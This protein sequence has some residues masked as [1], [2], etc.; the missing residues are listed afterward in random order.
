MKA[1]KNIL[2][3]IAA[4]I[5]LISGGLILLPATPLRAQGSGGTCSMGANFCY[6]GQVQSTFT[7]TCGSSTLITIDDYATGGPKDLIYTPGS[8][9]IFDNNNVMNIGGYLLGSYSQSGSCQYYVGE[10][11][12]EKESDGSMDSQ[13]GTGT[14]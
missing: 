2:D 6:G 1:R 10:S 3:G 14:S 4:L 12:E 9:R 13:P 7:C 8:S 5:I 11:C